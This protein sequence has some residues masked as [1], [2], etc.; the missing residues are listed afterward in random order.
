MSNRVAP[1]EAAFD[2]AERAGR[3]LM[4]GFMWRYH[5]QTAVLE[6]LVREGAIGPVRHVR[7]GF[8]FSLPSDSGDPRWDPELEGGA[9]MDIGCYCVSSLR[10]L[11]GE[12]VRVSAE[13]ITGGPEPGVDGRT[14]AVLRFD[15][16][17]LGSFDC[18]MDTVPGSV[19]E[20][21]GRDG[22]LVTHDPWHGFAPNL[23]RIAADGTREAIA[24]EAVDPYAREVD[25][26]SRAVRAGGRPRLGREDAVGQARTI[27]ALYRAAAEGREVAMR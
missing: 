11:L 6:R 24:V 18:G 12:P 26:V 17:V 23:T 14:A 8:W 1:V 9:L 7:A 2:T 22:T 27:E 20:V 15:G 5:E 16:D 19:L 25:D 10:L 21:R 13:Q 3:V 4:E